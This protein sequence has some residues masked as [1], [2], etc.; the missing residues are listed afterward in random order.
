MLESL[1][2]LRSH[3]VRAKVWPVEERL[4]GPRK[5]NKSCCQVC[6]HVIEAEIFQSFVD[7]KVYKRLVRRFL[8]FGKKVYKED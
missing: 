5:C 8:T 1:R 4:A 2:T 7:K 3:L 6:K